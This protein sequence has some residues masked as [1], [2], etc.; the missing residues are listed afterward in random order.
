MPCS[1]RHS[2]FSESFTAILQSYH[3][4]VQ[5]S[6]TKKMEKSERYREFQ[7]CC[8][9]V[10]RQVE[11]IQENLTEKLKRI[12]EKAA[13]LRHIHSNGG[14][15]LQAFAGREDKLA[16]YAESIMEKSKLLSAGKDRLKKHVDSLRIH[17]DSQIAECERQLTLLTKRQNMLAETRRILSE[18]NVKLYQ[19]ILEKSTR[20]QTL[21]EKHDN[22]MTSI[23]NLSLRESSISYE[24][25]ET[26][27]AS[28]QTD[29][30]QIDNEINATR[31]SIATLASQRSAL[32]LKN[33]TIRSDLIK[34]KR[35]LKATEADYKEST[36]KLASKIHH[37]IEK[38]KSSVQKQH[39]RSLETESIQD[40][41]DTSI[42][43]IRISE[44]QL[45]KMKRMAKTGKRKVRELRDAIDKIR[46][47]RKDF[48]Q[49]SQSARKDRR[50]L[51]EKLSE[52]KE[53][54]QQATQEQLQIRSGLAT[55][56]AE[57]NTVYQQKEIEKKNVEQQEKMSRTLCKVYETIDFAKQ[58]EGAL[59]KA[60]QRV[61][62]EKANHAE[63]EQDSEVSDAKRKSK[64]LVKRSKRDLQDIKDEI[65]LIQEQIKVVQEKLKGPRM[66][67]ERLKES[68][69]KKFKEVCGSDERLSLARVEES[70]KGESRKRKRT[71][72]RMNK[73]ISHLS[74]KVEE[75]RS[76]LE[77]KRD[78]IRHKKK[79]LSREEEKVAL[80]KRSETGWNCIWELSQSL[81][82][83]ISLWIRIVNEE[84]PVVLQRWEVAVN[85][86]SER[87]ESQ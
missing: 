21:A 43:D 78:R 81:K 2:A 72:K 55:V 39:D 32:T 8:N 86:M 17:L 15:S 38:R 60:M 68:V 66:E 47:Q 76:R 49:R 84:I 42:E 65:S 57:L 34:M 1:T 51:E 45:S 31:S 46:C 62:M 36:Q 25:D 79:K 53:R 71:L 4:N 29:I 52:A 67:V 48:E 23:Y 44:S 26:S 14:Q 41:N 12:A 73:G 74:D 70:L 3:L 10:D 61:R 56:R 59:K 64:H 75:A 28:L 85:D 6:E 7:R 33:Q 30:E 19:S 20:V 22:T 40:Q 37:Q 77:S 54:I 83:E 5:C 27:L 24:F 63:V 11:K 35:K 82:S 87:L 9:S 50:K 16:E 69:D 18:E 58:Q 13:M 80:F